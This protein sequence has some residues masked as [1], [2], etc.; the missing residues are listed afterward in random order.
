MFDLVWGLDPEVLESL[1]GS[2]LQRFTPGGVQETMWCQGLNACQPSTLTSDSSP[3]ILNISPTN[4]E[5]VILGDSRRCLSSCVASVYTVYVVNLPLLM[6]KMLFVS[7]I[8]SK[9]Q[10]VT[11]HAFMRF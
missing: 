7:S 8:I 11:M 6:V 10:Q 1:P 2:L 3:A 9:A 4:L 5:L